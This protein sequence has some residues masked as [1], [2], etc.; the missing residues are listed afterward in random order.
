MFSFTGPGYLGICLEWWIS[1]TKCMVINI[2]YKCTLSKKRALWK[3][4]LLRRTSLGGSV[5]CVLS[6]FNS[7]C[8]PFERVCVG[9]SEYWAEGSLCVEFSNFISHVE[10]WDLP[11]LWSRFIW[12]Q[13]YGRVSRRLDRVLILVDWWD[14]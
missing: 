10:L 12:F 8:S 7:I 9:S 1:K 11:L 6:D 2:Y 14:M 3:D 5:W 4:L 13:P